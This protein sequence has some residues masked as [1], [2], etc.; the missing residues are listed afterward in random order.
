MNDKVTFMVF[1]LNKTFFKLDSLKSYLNNNESAHSR[2]TKNPW[3]F[4]SREIFPFPGIFPF[5][6]GIFIPLLTE[7]LIFIQNWPS[8]TFHFENTDFR[9]LNP[10]IQRM[11]M[12]N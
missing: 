1:M 5:L 2:T 10:Q 8:M 3:C 7:Y 12:W 9:I 6:S 4:L 11:N